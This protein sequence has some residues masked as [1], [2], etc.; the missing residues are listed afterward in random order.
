MSAAIKPSA[1]FT[2]DKFNKHNH[3]NIYILSKCYRKSL[4]QFIMSD[5]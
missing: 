4:L 1:K 3:M 5:Y 2:T